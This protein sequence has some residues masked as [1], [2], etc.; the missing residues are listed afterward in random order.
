MGPHQ[1]RSQSDYVREE[2][3]SRLLGIIPFSP[4]LIHV[5]DLSAMYLYRRP[6]LKVH[7]EICQRT[8]EEYPP[9]LPRLLDV[10]NHVLLTGNHH[11]QLLN[12]VGSTGPSR[13]F[14][15]IRKTRRLS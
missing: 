7:R 15:E 11:P 10:I 2:M 6:S 5:Q 3:E 1:M 9:S 4:Y 14:S 13:V 12:D 8:S